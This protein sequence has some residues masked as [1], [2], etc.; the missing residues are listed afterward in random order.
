MNIKKPVSDIVSFEDL[1]L[2]LTTKELAG[3]FR[4]ITEDDFFISYY[5]EISH[6]I[7]N[8]HG[9]DYLKAMKNKSDMEKNKEL[10]DV[11]LTTAAAVTSY[12][13]IFMSKVKLDILNKGGEIYYTDTDSI[14]T[15]IPLKPEQVG[16][17]LGQFKLVDEIKEAYFI[18][19]KTYC[20][21][22]KNNKVIIKAKGL[23]NSSLKLKDF[24]NLYNGFIVK[25][26]KVHTVSTYDKGSVVIGE[27]KITLYP[28]TYK[29]RQKV[30]KFLR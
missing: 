3:T 24:K 13:R 28:D 26:M 12:A 18:S 2:I 23:K 9:V 14:F 5:P 20:L 4:Q 8:S 29:K 27:K 25:G 21:L 7:C 30:Y 6:T 15:N 22:L 16:D 10:R 17:G 19:S 11:S 1:E